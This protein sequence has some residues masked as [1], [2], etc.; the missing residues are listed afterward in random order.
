[1]NT[2]RLLFCLGLL[3]SLTFVLQSC[4]DPVTPELLKPWVRDG[5]TLDFR[6]HEDFNK[7]VGVVGDTSTVNPNKYFH[8][9][10][11]NNIIVPDSVAFEDLVVWNMFAADNDSIAA[12]DWKDYVI[13]TGPN[14][15][16]MLDVERYKKAGKPPVGLDAVI[17][18]RSLQDSITLRELGIRSNKHFVVKD[19]QDP[20]NEPDVP[21]VDPQLTCTGYTV[22]RYGMDERHALTYYV[23][24]T[25]VEGMRVAII[26]GVHGNEIAGWG[27]A[28]DIIADFPFTEGKVLVLPKAN[29]LACDLN[30]RFPGNKSPGNYLPETNNYSTTLGY[31]DMARVF[32]GKSNGNITEKIAWCI[33]EILDEFQPE[34]IFD[35][36]E[37]QRPYSNGADG[38]MGNTLLA[39]SNNRAANEAAVAAINASG[40]APE[41]N[42]VLLTSITVGMTNT[43]FGPRYNAPAFIIETIRY[44]GLTSPLVTVPLARRISQ[45]RFLIKAIWDNYN[46]Q[47]KS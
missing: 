45:H 22:T 14:D 31:V 17:G 24:D 32:P 34:L 28:L 11:K 30:D 23:F 18:S 46:K 12:I 15:T 47:S 7:N 4:N 10:V 9:D 27:A 8:T 21:P 35:L 42:F 13:G 6:T 2:K 20:E 43:A 44:E 39:V 40:L 36:H 3:L 37:S 19:K 5:M 29:K 38:Y 33:T 25:G 1:M 26:G 16:I 41:K